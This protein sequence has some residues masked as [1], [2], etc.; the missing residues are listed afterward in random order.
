MLGSTLLKEADIQIPFKLLLI[1]LLIVIVPFFVGFSLSLI[2]SKLRGLFLKIAKPLSSICVALL[3]SLLFITKF[4]S[5]KLLKWQY[6]IAGMI[7][8]DL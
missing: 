4:Y 3:L 5:F 2:F 7:V 6:F 1:N 8:F